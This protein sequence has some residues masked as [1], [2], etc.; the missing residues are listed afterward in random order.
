MDMAIRIITMRPNMAGDR[1]RHIT[2]RMAV[3]IIVRGHRIVVRIR[4]TITITVTIPI[5]TIVIIIDNVPL[6]TMG[7][8]RRR[9]RVGRLRTTTT[10]MAAAAGSLIVAAGPIIE[11]IAI[12]EAVADLVRHAEGAVLLGME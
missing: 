1:R 8:H 5:T 3:G 9:R 2:T 6:T 4:I 11:D 10:I 12:R 7:T